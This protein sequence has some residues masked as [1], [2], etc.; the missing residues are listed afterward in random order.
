MNPQSKEMMVGLNELQSVSHHSASASNV[1]RMVIDLGIA[2]SKV[3]DLWLVC[4]LSDLKQLNPVAQIFSCIQVIYKVGSFS[5]FNINN[6]TDSFGSIWRCKRN[7]MKPWKALQTAYKC[8][9]ASSTGW[10][11]FESQTNCAILS[12][13]SYH[14][15]RSGQ[16]HSEMAEKSD[17]Y[18][19]VRLNAFGTN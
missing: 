8:S 1:A 7:P 15:R 11:R 5:V 13:S 3:I 19:S 17:A 10:R 14:H 18:V 12:Q 16:L 6:I 9:L 2:A 4:M